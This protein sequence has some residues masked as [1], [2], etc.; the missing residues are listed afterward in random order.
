VTWRVIGLIVLAVIVLLGTSFIPR[1]WSHPVEYR[2]PRP[3]WWFFGDAVWRG[4][5]RSLPA[6]VIGAWFL[7]L[8]TFGIVLSNRKIIDESVPVW[9]GL[10]FFLFG[11]LAIT[12]A[13]F[14]WPKFLVPPSLR[15]EPGAVQ[16]WLQHR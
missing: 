6:A 7:I 16:E 2:P 12:I 15:D 8:A 10:G 1:Y 3:E 9:L 13:L 11:V 4:F 14:N 5:L